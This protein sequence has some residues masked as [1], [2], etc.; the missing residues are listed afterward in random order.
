MKENDTI[1]QFEHV[2]KIFPD[3][4]IAVED[5]SLDIKRGEFVTLLG[6]SGCGKTTTLRML[7]GF[8]SPSKGKIILD[9]KDITSLPPYKR[10]LNTV[11]QHYALFPN[12][13]VY[14]NVAF[15]LK[16]KK[17]PVK[18]KNRKGEEVIKY[19]HLDRRTIDLKVAKALEIVNMED[20]EDRDVQSLSGGQQQR[21]AIARAIVNEPEVLLLDEPL[22]A[23]DHKMRKDM[24]LELKEMH[25]KLGITFVYVTHD[26]E[27]ALSM[28]TTVV[29]MKDGAI[30]QVGTPEDIYN[31]PVNAYVA[32]FIGESNIYNA[33]MV[34]PKMV[35]F[36]GGVFPCVDDFKLNEKV[37]VVV[38]PEDVIISEKN[39]GIINGKIVSK[40][41]KGE[42]YQYI[43]L[44]GKNEVL[45]RGTKNYALNE[46][47]GLKV[48]P[49]NI[50][51]MKKELVSNVYQDAYINKDNEV[52]LAESFPFPCDLTQ[53]IKGSYMEEGYLV[54]PK[55][56]KKYDLA[57][58]EADVIAEV[59]LDKVQILDNLEEGHAR[60][61]I[62]SSVWLGDH[63]QYIVRTDEEEDFVLDT[64]YQYD[65]GAEVGI[66][67]N[68]EDIKLKLKK[69]IENYE[70]TD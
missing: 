15:G 61:R 42:M 39:K 49:E 67:I 65:L 33:T 26:Q 31:E 12:L 7:A 30:Q 44:V 22:S 32:D 43:A 68:K 3:G 64:V 46:E 21:V 51:V 57:T 50:Q 9:G 69:G 60:G 14:D 52:V 16:L 70:V 10:P 19:K 55:T 20:M 35:R 18:V 45:I 27:E 62:C 58:S 4:F 13:D 59:P 25:E 2:S 36:L 37:D 48:D 41:F 1:I 11:F 34:G 23:L 38:R 24:Q 5:F 8:D 47:I 53:L 54:D 63:Y 56:K 17:V 29:V 66:E 6:P 40:I 28:S